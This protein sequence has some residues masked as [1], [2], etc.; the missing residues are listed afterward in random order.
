M[1]EEMKLLSSQY[2]NGD[3]SMSDISSLFDDANIEISSVN[4]NDNG[5]GDGK[6]GTICNE[7]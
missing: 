6:H 4:D 5:D 7:K 3:I 2:Q 1:E